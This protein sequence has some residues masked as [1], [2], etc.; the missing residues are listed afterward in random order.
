MAKSGVPVVPTQAWY[1]GQGWA[2]YTFDVCGQSFITEPL[3]VWMQPFSPSWPGV[4]T[5]D[6]RIYYD[7]YPWYP[8]LQLYATASAVPSQINSGDTSQ[9]TIHIT[10]DSGVPVGGANI[11]LSTT[12]GILDPIIGT[13]DINGDFTS[14]YTAPIV[15]DIQTFTVTAITSKSGYV[16]GSGSTQIIVITTICIVK[17]DEGIYSKPKYCYIGEG[18]I[19]KKV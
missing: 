13:T 8:S 18:I 3:E 6:L 11:N 7:G 5:N 16:D 12:N 1:P 17:R 2:T 14:T 10:D 19:T 15:T 4:Y 9:I